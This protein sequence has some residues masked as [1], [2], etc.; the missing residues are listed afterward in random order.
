MVVQVLDL[1]VVELRVGGDVAAEVGFPV[2]EEL[3]ELVGV[4][5]AEP[6]LPR[7]PVLEE[8]MVF[9]GLPVAEAFL[10]G[11]EVGEAEELAIWKR[12]IGRSTSFLLLLLATELQTSSDYLYIPSIVVHR[13]PNFRQVS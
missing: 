11:I 8:L 2:L 4:S 3:V 10:L 6:L 1:V 7:L 5:V 9:L 12:R 13:A